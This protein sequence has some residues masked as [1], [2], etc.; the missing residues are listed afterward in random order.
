MHIFSLFIYKKSVFP[1]IPIFPTFCNSFACQLLQSN[2]FK[3]EIFSPLFV[4]KI[5]EKRYSVG[6]GGKLGE[7]KYGDA[8]F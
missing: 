7:T 4:V 3:M 2:N 5:R 6:N 8:I 1:Q